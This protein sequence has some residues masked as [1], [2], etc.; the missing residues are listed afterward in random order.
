MGDLTMD[1]VQKTEFGQLL[2]L[3]SQEEGTIDLSRFTLQRYKLIVKYKTSFYSFYLSVA[4][5]MNMCGI[6]D[7][8]YYVTAKK[9]CMIMGEYFQIQDDYLDCYGD[10]KHIGK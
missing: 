4:M 5:A 2:D 10:P 1:I 3:T 8:E 7:E 9:I 6:T